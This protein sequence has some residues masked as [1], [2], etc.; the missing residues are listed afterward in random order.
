[1]AEIHASFSQFLTH[2]TGRLD[3]CVLPLF[4]TFLRRLTPKLLFRLKSRYYLS[5]NFGVN[6]N[7]QWLLC[8]YTELWAGSRFVLVTIGFVGVA[9]FV[10]VMYF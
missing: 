4:W 7:S 2:P 1:M 3:K 9:V 6:G 10:F 8:L 5:G